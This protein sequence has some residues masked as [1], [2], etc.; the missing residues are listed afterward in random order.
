LNK[1]D[2][3]AQN[4]DAILLA[5][6]GIWLHMLGKYHKKFVQ[7]DRDLDIKIPEDLTQKFPMLDRLLRDSW[8]SNFW[9][10][11]PVSDLT[12]HN[13]SIYD[14]IQYHRGDREKAK[15][16]SSGLLKLVY[17]SHGRGSGTEKGVIF[18]KSYDEQDDKQTYTHV[19][20]SS[21]F[22][23][24]SE[25]IDLN[26][27]SNRKYQLYQ[28]LENQLTTLKDSLT[29]TLPWDPD[30][31]R[32][33]RQP[34]IDGLKDDF[35][36]TVGDTR[37][38]IND[39]TLWDQ[40][41]ATVAFFKTELAEVLL[42]GWR[43]PL[44]GNNR[45]KYRVLRVVFDADNF[46]AQSP[47]IGDVLAREQI[48]KKA[49]GEVKYLIDVDYPLGLEIYHDTNSIVFLTPDISDLLE[50]KDGQNKTF[51]Q[52]IEERF[53]S[54]FNGEVTLDISLSSSGSRNVFFVGKEITNPVKPLSPTFS[55]LKESWKVA[56][57]KCSICQVRPQGYGAELI[58]DYKNNFHYYSQKAS[59]R[60]MCCICMER[61]QGR[62][63]EWATEKVNETI[64]IDEV[65]DI[66]GRIALIAG[67]FDLEH[68][69]NGELISTFRNPK[70]YCGAKF[71]EIVQDLSQKPS[72]KL[73]NL[74]KYKMIA[75]TFKREN[76]DIKGLAELLI[77]DEDLGET[78]FSS[79]PDNEKLALTVWR[80]PPSFARLR[81]VWE[82]T[83]D[84]WINSME[85]KLKDIVGTVNPRL[86]ITGDVNTSDN[87]GDNHAYDVELKKGVETSFV[88]DKERGRFI[89]VYNLRYLAKRL[90]LQGDKKDLTN[91]EA[92]QKIKDYIEVE[93]K[94]SLDLY[95]DLA[96]SG[97]PIKVAT[98]RQCKVTIEQHNY[99]PAIPILADPEQFMALVPSE[100]A[101]DIAN[102]IRTEYEVQFSKVKN[103][104]PL[105]LN[106]VFF[107]RKQPLYAALDAARRMLSRKSRHD[108]LWEIQSINEADAQEICTHSDGRLTN[109]CKRIVLKRIDANTLNQACEILV[110]YGLGDPNKKD[111]WHP[112]FFAETKASD[113]QEFSERDYHFS[114]PFSNK[115]GYEMKD[116]VHVIDL[117][118]GDQIYYSPST[119]D[120]QFLD[121]TTRRYELVYE[122][123]MRMLRS[124]E[125]W[126]TRS[127]LLEDLVII[128]RL[129]KALSELTSAQIQ[130]LAG[131]LEDWH[132]RW[133]IRQLGDKTYEAFATYALQRAF[134]K[135]S[136]SK[137][138]QSD[139]ISWAVSGRLFD[140]LELYL[141]ILKLKPEGDKITMEAQI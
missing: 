91:E 96:Q 12:P 108:T 71:S 109:S 30:R 51:H 128:D 59:K 40:T 135:R 61:L 80:K 106:I 38:P 37:R 107:N 123:E 21:A 115:N 72:K 100:K 97:K 88:Y 53:N 104:L 84:F 132:E 27:L 92:A 23:Y 138:D 58:V 56:T 137:T 121:I 26:Q 24:E 127:F 7:V 54:V 86:V 67:R 103:R 93:K 70:D 90:G 28:F 42:T 89:N 17:D 118:K 87:L 140:L 139:L 99:L 98:I 15:K 129:W 39:V 113:V 62:S 116:L 1:L 2:A 101:L 120:F 44:D 130:Q 34:F 85:S 112:Y 46:I 16:Y 68:W 114:A 74:P 22:G 122:H 75:E 31:W 83:Q 65:A 95:E 102:H 49:F 52:L 55:F 134:G 133:Q 36:T 45:F 5:E 125:S 126:A 6:V 25:P 94:G 119:L 35:S 76:I 79:T 14:F 69:L 10:K 64:W 48:I 18:S 60:K 124:H 63:K 82:T 11:L 81:R 33:W 9:V 66:N 20:L 110:S 57:D 8:P 141:K 47:R 117:K 131:L 73:T 50:L 4:R 105:H 77:Q 13:L 136:L 111:V 41:A 78:E 32:R 3:L 19:H 43:D 29:P